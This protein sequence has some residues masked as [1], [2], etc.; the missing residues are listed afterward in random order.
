MFKQL[1][2]DLI[3]IS[4]SFTLL[5]FPLHT[6]MPTADNCVGVCVVGKVSVT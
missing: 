4:I 6:I 2:R 3:S 1:M 5:L